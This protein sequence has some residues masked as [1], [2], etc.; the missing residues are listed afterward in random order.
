[1]PLD[2]TPVRIEIITLSKEHS[3]LGLEIGNLFDAFAEFNIVERT[4]F[5][6]TGDCGSK[7]TKEK[8]YS[9]R[10]H[11]DFNKS[12]IVAYKCDHDEDAVILVTTCKL[13]KE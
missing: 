4:F 11:F 5:L 12:P 10:Y 8:R 1:M 9:N 3:K 2:N 13:V 6:G 7:T